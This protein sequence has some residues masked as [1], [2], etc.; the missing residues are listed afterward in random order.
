MEI[1]I[2]EAAGSDLAL[3]S[4]V[5]TEAALWLRESGRELWA[6]EDVSASRV[7]SDVHAGLYVLAWS[8]PA[9]VGTMRLTPSDP[10]FWPE[11]ARG[12]GLYLHRLAVRRA[13][14]GGQVSSAL[15]SR[16]AA[17]AVARGMRYLRLDC[18]ASRVSLRRV[19]ERFGFAFHSE[20][21][22][23]RFVVARYQLL[24]EQAA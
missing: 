11:A 2:R 7:A 13:V 14:S 22:V 23:G 5:L 18:E 17:T 15:L 1:E 4:E 24:C 19:Y 6:P 12:E 3:V 16:A 9:A 10:T 8:G 20:R 21:T